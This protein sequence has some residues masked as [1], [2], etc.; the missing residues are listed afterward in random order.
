MKIELLKNGV[1]QINT[2]LKVASK[3]QEQFAMTVNNDTMNLKF[4]DPSHVCMANLDLRNNK[5]YKLESLAK[6]LN[7]KTFELSVKDVSKIL[8]RVEDNTTT[9]NAET[10]KSGELLGINFIITSN[11]TNEVIKEIQIPAFNYE[12]NINIPD[13][14]YGNDIPLARMEI[15]NLVDSIH[16]INDYEADAIKITNS[17]TQLNFEATSQNNIRKKIK[18]N[19]FETV[20]FVDMSEKEHDGTEKI[21]GFYSMDFL[22][23]LVTESK[24]YSKVDIRYND[25]L[26][27]SFYYINEESNDVGNLVC[28]LAPRVE[29]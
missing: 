29:D 5:H 14:G 28:I 15:E 4:I 3:Y 19:K 13:L 17:G 16:E 11:D 8:A 21:E 10:D 24:A 9:V 26:P 23:H 25:K 20:D 1:D 12:Q 27:V 6:P 18:I 7:D 22:N 2:F